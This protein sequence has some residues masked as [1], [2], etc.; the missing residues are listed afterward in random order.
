LMGL[1]RYA[2]LLDI[3]DREHLARAF[4]AL[5]VIATSVSVLRLRVR[6]GHRWLAAAAEEICSYVTSR[7]P[8]G[9]RH[10]ITDVGLRTS[11]LGPRIS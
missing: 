4:E 10:E 2:Y 1:V 7:P 8:E 3:E 9:G 6:H 11:D 5:A